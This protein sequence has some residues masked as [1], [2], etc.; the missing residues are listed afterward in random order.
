MRRKKSEVMEVDHQRLQDVADRAKKSLD[1]KDAE[2]IERVFDSYEYVADLIQAKNLT[3]GR[4]QK[5]L[6]GAKTEKTPKVVG[7][8]TP[9]QA[10]SGETG[11]ARGPS[12]EDAGETE[13]DEADADGAGRPPPGGHGRNAAAAYRGAER[14]VVPHAS[15]GPGDACPECGKGTV[16]EKSP[17][18]SCESPGKLPFPP[19]ATNCKNCVAICAARCS[20][21]R[22]PRRPGLR[23]T[24]RRQ[25][26]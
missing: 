11:D 9:S 1:P 12:P 13:S 17:A 18:S 4:L 26:A 24:T 14:I 15:L 2:L 3:I 25:P 10:A 6:F 7:N 23:S 21:P 8:S 20:A 22:F 19:C 5:M 16:Y